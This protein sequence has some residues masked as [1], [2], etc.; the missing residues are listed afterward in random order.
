M[1]FLIALGI[2]FGVVLLV[3]MIAKIIFWVQNK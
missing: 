3:I 2:I 1:G